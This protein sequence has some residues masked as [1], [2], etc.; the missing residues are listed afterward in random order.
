MVRP[1]ITEEVAAVVKVC[2]ESATA[3]VPQGGNTGH[4]HGL[5]APRRGGTRS[6]SRSGGMNRI[7]DVDAL[8][9]TITAEA[10]V[11][12][13]NIQKRPPR[14]IVSFRLSLGAKASCTIGGNLSTNAGGVNVLRYGNTRDL[15]LGLE[16]VLPDGRIWN[17]LARLRKDN[18]GYDLKQLFIGAEGTLGIITAAV[19]KLFPAQR[20]RDRVERRAEPRR[21]RSSCSRFCA[22]TAAIASPPSS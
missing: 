14:P 8:D 4:V 20:L 11:V 19:L 1:A 18:T 12:L 22:V 10:G 2:A 13:A 5:G 7:R 17:G 21:L 15:V 3:I 16:V 9:N 6:C